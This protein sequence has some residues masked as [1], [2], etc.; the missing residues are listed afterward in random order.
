VNLV[1]RIY[2]L[3]ISHH[4]LLSFKKPDISDNRGLS[5]SFQ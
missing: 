1:P 2:S 5:R 4:A 3:H